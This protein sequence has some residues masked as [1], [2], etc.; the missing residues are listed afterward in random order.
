MPEKLKEALKKQNYYVTSSLRIANFLMMEGVFPFEVKND[1][2]HPHI[3][4][5]FYP[6]NP[7]LRAC[8]HKWYENLDKK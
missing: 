2:D 8:L 6:N 7:T 4:V 5:F 1:K 3:K